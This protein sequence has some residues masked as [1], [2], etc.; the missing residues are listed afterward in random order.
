[1][2][3]AA[4]V[5][6]V[7]IATASGGTYRTIPFTSANLNRGGTMLEDTELVANSGHRSRQIGLLDWSVGGSANWKASGVG[8]TALN[9]LYSGLT[10]RLRLWVRYLPAG[11]GNLAVGFRG[12]VR[13]ESING[14]GD[15]DGLETLDISLQSTGRL[16]AAN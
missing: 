7:Q 16:G 13:V 5:K 2:A 1:M 10:S 14:S 11:T 8:R 15:V 12:P 3:Q 4:Y 6:R 9:T